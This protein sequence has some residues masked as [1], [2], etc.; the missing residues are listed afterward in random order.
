MTKS[1]GTET[2]PAM[3]LTYR[4]HRQRM[5]ERTEC[6]TEPEN[7]AG[8][9]FGDQ[10]LEED[11]RTS[12]LGSAQEQ[13]EPLLSELRSWQSAGQHDNLTLIVIDVA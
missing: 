1:F 7:S 13:S 10:G 6:L 2:W 4:L 3:A 12:R 9:Q 8:A 5:L 11:T